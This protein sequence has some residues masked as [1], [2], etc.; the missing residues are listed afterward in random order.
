MMMHRNRWPVSAR[1][2]TLALTL[3]ALFGGF[4]VLVAFLWSVGSTADWAV[5]VWHRWAMNLPEAAWC[6]GCCVTS[7]GLLLAAGAGLSHL[8][9]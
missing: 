8:T 3:M 1:S 6:V 5:P 2:L 9:R 7:A 4:T